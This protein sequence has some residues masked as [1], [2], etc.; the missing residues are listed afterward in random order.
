M[1]QG[2]THHGVLAHQDHTLSA[3]RL[4]DLV[5][6]LRRDIV[7]RDDEDGFVL[8]QQAL[9]LVEVASLVSRFAP[10]IFLFFEG[11]IFKGGYSV[12]DGGKR[13]FWFGF[14]AREKFSKTCKFRCELPAAVWGGYRSRAWWG[15]PIRSPARG[16]FMPH[17]RGTKVHG[18]LLFEGVPSRTGPDAQWLPFCKLQGFLEFGE[19]PPSL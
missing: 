19:L 17:H 2:Q 7:D 13:E 14:A 10:H 15:W 18:R 12:D 5:H 16:S 11:R 6:L 4:P 3:E 9:E 8:L 1:S